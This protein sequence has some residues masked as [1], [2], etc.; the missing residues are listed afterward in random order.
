MIK[1]SDKLERELIKIYEDCLNLE[2]KKDL[3]EYG[4]WGMFI[5][6]RVLN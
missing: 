5:L 4:E 3:T 6:E 2:K 1:I